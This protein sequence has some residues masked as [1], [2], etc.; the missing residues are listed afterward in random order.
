MTWIQRWSK[1]LI[2]L[3]GVGWIIQAGFSTQEYLDHPMV[4]VRELLLRYGLSFI[5]LI[6]GFLTV[7]KLMKQ[8][9]YLGLFSLSGGLINLF[10][11]LGLVLCFLGLLVIVEKRS[12]QKDA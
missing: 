1:I 7:D 12:T 5:G 3:L 6:L 9:V 4:D 2:L 11:W 10:S 8:K